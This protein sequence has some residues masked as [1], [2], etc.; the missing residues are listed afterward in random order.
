[1]SNLED[2]HT[3][4]EQD[5][6]LPVGPRLQAFLECLLTEQLG[7]KATE[8]L[9]VLTNELKIQVSISRPKKRQTT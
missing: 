9:V 3:H 8:G 5:V 2:F 4:E 6:V 1:M 7:L